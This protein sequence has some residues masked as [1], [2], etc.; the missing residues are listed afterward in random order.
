MAGLKQVGRG[1]KKGRAVIT[2]NFEASIGAGESYD[3]VSITGS[4]NI[5]VIIKGGTHGDI[6]TVGMLVN[7]V[8]KVLD[9]PPGLKTM[10]DLIISA[11]Q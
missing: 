8:P 3:S 6:A 1:L 9:A 5:E 2:L 4:P 10:R 7:A 11:T